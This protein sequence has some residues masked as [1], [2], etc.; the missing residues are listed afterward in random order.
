MAELRRLHAIGRED[1]FSHDNLRALLGAESLADL[2]PDRLAQFSGAYSEW[3]ETEVE[4][5]RNLIDAESLEELRSAWEEI[6]NGQRRLLAS[7]KDLR[8]Q[9][10]S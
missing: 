7:A 8:K 2:Q 3:T 4:R 5:A 1:G 6:Q 9:A 10:L